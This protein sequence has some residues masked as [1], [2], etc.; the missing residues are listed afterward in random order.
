MNAYYFFW[1]LAIDLMVTYIYVFDFNWLSLYM[2][3]FF[4]DPLISTMTRE[5]SALVF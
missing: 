1:N 4:Q 2:S 3:F 5:L